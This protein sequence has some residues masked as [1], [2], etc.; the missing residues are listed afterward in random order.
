MT[1]R[2]LRRTR[3]TAPALAARTLRAAGA[4]LLLAC[5]ARAAP[6]AP[7][8]APAVNWASAALGATATA[9]SSGY[10]AGCVRAARA[11]RKAWIASDEQ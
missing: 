1:P 2:L 4:A 6:T 9:S 10:W 11:Q 5:T 8:L 3:R 7:P